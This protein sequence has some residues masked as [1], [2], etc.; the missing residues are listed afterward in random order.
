VNELLHAQ[1]DKLL[2][3]CDPTLRGL[4]AGV[5]AD[6]ELEIGIAKACLNWE[7]AAAPALCDRCDSLASELHDVR[8][9]LARSLELNDR[10]AAENARLNRELDA[11]VLRAATGQTHEPAEDG[12]RARERMRSESPGPFVRRCSRS[13]CQAEASEIDID[14]ADLCRSCYEM[15]IAARAAQVSGPEVRDAITA[16]TGPDPSPDNPANTM[17]DEH[18]AD[19][20]PLC[21]GDG[22]SPQRQLDEHDELEQELVASLG[23]AKCDAAALPQEPTPPPVSGPIRRVQIVQPWKASYTPE[24]L[25]RA[26]EIMATEERVGQGVLDRV[27]ETCSMS[28]SQARSARINYHHEIKAVESASPEQRPLVLGALRKH[29]QARVKAA[30]T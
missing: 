30:K 20:A 15:T 19:A 14:G 5:I 8:D 24:D 11:M 18:P 26:I 22:E 12:E 29:F 2:G 28:A 3:G 27:A 23:R 7:K 4:L 13:T 25:L 10:L 17:P 6:F 16:P 1:V 9:N 21:V